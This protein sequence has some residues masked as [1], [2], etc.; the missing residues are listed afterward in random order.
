[1]PAR[2]TCSTARRRCVYRHQN[3]RSIRKNPR[4]AVRQVR[5][6]PGHSANRQSCVTRTSLPKWLGGIATAFPIKC[7]PNGSERTLV[8]NKI[9]DAARPRL[10]PGRSIRSCALWVSALARIVPLPASTY[11]G[12]SWR[13][14]G[15]N[16]VNALRLVLKSS[17]RGRNTP[18]REGRRPRL[19]LAAYGRKGKPL[20]TLVK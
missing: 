10:N 13:I 4:S 7:A 11:R 20:L 12:P 15:T 6:P 2:L 3:G 9:Q 18:L 16:P 8:S 17:D 1:M 14:P 19:L 5:R